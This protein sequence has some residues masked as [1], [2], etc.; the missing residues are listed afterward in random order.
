MSQLKSEIAAI[1]AAEGPISVERF[2]ALALGHPRH[3]YYMT[4]DPFGR[5]GDFI[6]APEVSQMFGELIGLWA[7]SVWQT[8]GAPDKLRLVE[9]GPGRGTLMAD[10]LRAGRVLPGFSE[11]V[12]VHLV[13][14]SPVLRAAQKASL[15]GRVAALHWHDRVEDLPPG[16]AVIVANEFFDALP[17]R[18][19]VRQGGVWRERL[20]GL[21]AD[22]RLVF[23]LAA[24]SEPRLTQQAG[25]GAVLEVPLVGHGI[26]RALAQ[27]LAADGGALLAIDYGHLATAPGDT[28]QAMKNHKP[29]DPLAEPGEADLTAHVDFAA[30]GRAALA[31]GAVLQGPVTQRVFLEALGL[32]A[33]ADRLQRSGS[34]DQARAIAG[35]RERLVEGGR[36]GMGELFKV[37]AVTHPDLPMLPGFDRLTTPAEAS[38]EEP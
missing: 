32:G 26:V 21:G 11:A 18:Q 36:T 22:G 20:V 2:M 15:A 30:L 24:E 34:P 3:G 9:L 14:T 5:A 37:M 35:Q 13:E 19:F 28:L 16:P 38:G 12:D 23:G 33:R 4:R 6:T 10:L 17:V 7:A 8:M 25:E 29:V 1:I 27:R 31:A